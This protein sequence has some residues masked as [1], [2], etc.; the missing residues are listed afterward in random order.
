MQSKSIS[1]KVYVDSYELDLLHDKITAFCLIGED[2]KDIDFSIN[3]SA[4]ETWVDENELRDYEKTIS[5][6][7]LCEADVMCRMEWVELYDDNQLLYKLLKEYIE[8]L[9]IME[10]TDG[11][12]APLKQILSEYKNAAI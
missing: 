4:F 9:Y 5:Y 1:P 10:A 12:L 7:G 8:H 3:Q 2:E 11:F 6:D